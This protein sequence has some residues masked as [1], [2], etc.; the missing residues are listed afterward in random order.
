MLAFDAVLGLRLDSAQAPEEVFESDP[1]I[2]GLLA[3]RQQAR[4][5]KDFEKADRIRAELDA[6]GL[7]IIDTPEG[8]RWRRK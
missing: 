1:R 5:D 4:A 2:D 3:E 8:S 6:E 7:V